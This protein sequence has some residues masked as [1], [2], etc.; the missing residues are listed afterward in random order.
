MIENSLLE[1]LKG[2]SDRSAVGQKLFKCQVIRAK[3]YELISY[4]VEIL[5]EN[6]IYDGAERFLRKSYDAYSYHKS[7]TIW[8]DIDTIDYEKKEN[9]KRKRIRETVIKVMEINK[10][11]FK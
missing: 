2:G 5:N 1:E 8:E 6:S 9:D 7:N 3:A 10:L 4:N 11:L